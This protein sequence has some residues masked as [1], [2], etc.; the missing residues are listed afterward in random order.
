MAV[1]LKAVPDKRSPEREALAAAIA[2]AAAAHRVAMKARDAK[3][4]AQDMAAAAEEKLI[5]ARVALQYLYANNLMPEAFMAEAKNL[6]GFREFASWP[7]NAEYHRWDLHPEHL[8]W[9][10][11]REALTHALFA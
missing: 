8:K 2:D 11:L 4:R 6:L 1:K 5:S 7:G 10:T 9:A 3:A